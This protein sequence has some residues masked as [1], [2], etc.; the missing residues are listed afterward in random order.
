MT[1]Y[2][3]I[4]ILLF[5]ALATISCSKAIT[6]CIINRSE[7][8]INVIDHQ[9][10]LLCE[11]GQMVSF[12]PEGESGHDIAIQTKD[13]T[14]FYSLTNVPMSFLDIVHDKRMLFAYKQDHKLYLLIPTDK[15]L[16]EDVSSQPA[17]YP[18]IPKEN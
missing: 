14:F 17:N 4:C 18:L 7:I 1:K 5:L 6:I 9:K 13:E 11:P 10:V 8:A 2:R 15:P 3:V 16:D 12:I